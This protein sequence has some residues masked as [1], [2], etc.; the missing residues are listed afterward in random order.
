MKMNINIQKFDKATRAN[1]WYIYPMNMDIPL[2][3]KY[4]RS[5]GLATLKDGDTYNE[6]LGEKIAILKAQ[7][8]IY[9]QVYEELKEKRDEL[10][11]ELEKVEDEMAKFS[12]YKLKSTLK[13]VEL[14]N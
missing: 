6:E 4:Y 1:A 12:T 10:E 13:I 8:N 5:T 7:R 14:A 9:S 11:K 3:D 2:D